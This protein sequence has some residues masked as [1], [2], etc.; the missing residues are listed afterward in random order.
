MASDQDSWIS[1][2]LGVDVGAIVSSVASAADTASSAA[3]GAVDDVKSAVSSATDSASSV[4]SGAVD[5]VK[6][7]A[8]S[9]A[10]TASTVASSA[11]KEVKS[12]VDDTVKTVTATVSDVRSGV[13]TVID[14]GIKGV[15]ST[16]S[17]V[18]DDAKAAESTAEDAASATWKGAKA[19]G[20]ALEDEAKAEYQD[21][22]DDDALVKEG[23]G[24]ADKG[25]DW[26]EN[27]AK[28]GA[29]AVADEAKG[30]PVLEQVAKGVETTVD[31]DVDF[32]GGA[33]KAVVG[34]VGGVV[35]AVA[36]PVDTAKALYTMSE[37]IPVVGIPGKAL[38]E[39]YDVATTDKTLEQ[40]G[41]E[42]VDPADDAKYW[43]KVGKGVWAPIQKSIDDGKPME[44]VGQAAVQIGALFTGAGE[45]ADAAEVADVADCLLYTSRCV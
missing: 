11:A 15:S 20:G 5:D 25:I 16:V 3:A 22:K 36:D 29:K 19:A 43:G 1:S 45:V 21:M 18:V 35:G 28:S 33:D 40:A 2:A 41:K 14:T 17:T 37:H 34:M 32:I 8:S 27:E 13:N 12:T 31:Q 30:I 9:A 26:L 44:G 42:M 23:Q 10:D 38:A 7:A 6:S 4:A 24:Y 39:A